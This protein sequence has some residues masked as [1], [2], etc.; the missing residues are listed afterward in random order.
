MDRLNRSF[1]ACGLGLMLAATGCRTTKP[2]VPPGRPFAKDGQQRKAI[3][4][5]S[6]GHPLNGAATANFMPNNLGGSNMASGIGAGGSRPDASAFGAPPGAY[7]PPGTAGMGQPG[8]IDPATSRA[9]DA[10]AE[11]PPASLP[12]PE[13]APASSSPTPLP[14]DKPGSM[15][16]P[17]QAPSPME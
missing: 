2:E 1:V 13:P 9:S 3:E 5:S 7:G 14:L 16:A 8:T 6:D 12:A 4:F 17:D 11:M 15:G 10:P